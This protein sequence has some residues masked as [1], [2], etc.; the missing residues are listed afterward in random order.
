MGKVASVLDCV[1]PDTCN[2][3]VLG[4]RGTFRDNRVWSEEMFPGQTGWAEIPTILPD[5]GDVTHHPFTGQIDALVAALLDGARVLPDLDD[6]V[7][8][9]EIIFAAD[10]AAETGEPVR[11]PLE[12]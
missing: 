10:R 11:L 12:R 5:S 3:D 4:T 1:M 7:K 8:T 2:V 6:A 9:H